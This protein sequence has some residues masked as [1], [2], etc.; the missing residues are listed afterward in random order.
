MS[1]D[2][3]TLIYQ[4][5][6][7]KRHQATGLISLTDLWQAQCA[8]TQQRPLA[9]VRLEATQKLLKHLAGQTG[10]EPLYAERQRSGQAAERL[11]MAIP[12]GLETLETDGDLQTYA[13]LELAVVYAR[14]LSA[15]CYEWALA[16]L[17]EAPHLA[18]QW[19]RVQTQAE[20]QTERRSMTRRAVIA[21]GWAIPVVTTLGL[22]QR[23][24]AQVSA[25]H[26]D[27][28]HGDTA[29]SDAAHTDHGD[30]AHADGAHGDAPHT[31]TVHGDTA[32]AD[33][34]HVDIL[35]DDAP[36]PPYTDHFDIGVH[37]DTVGVHGD[38]AH[39]DIAHADAH[40]DTVHGDL[41]HS[42]GIHGDSAHVDNP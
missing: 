26:T 1:Q 13:T 39:T 14:Y 24:A 31:D 20:R 19:Q 40:T 10:I 7:I 12:D 35:H 28:A 6:P 15:D 29:H 38:I 4:G 42:D 3:L 34:V 9:W 17:V 8:P 5:L 33:T 16:N 21:A 23:A 37:I 11:I 36:P 30:V 41:A 25:G 27:T 32:H 18:E 22:S 2:F